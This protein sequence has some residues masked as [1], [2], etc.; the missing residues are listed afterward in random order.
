MRSKEQLHSKTRSAQ[1][2]S[3]EKK[4]VTLPLAE[5]YI[6]HVLCVDLDGTLV[7]SREANFLAYSRAFQH[8]G[9]EL[10]RELFDRGFGLRAEEFFFTTASGASEDE[11]RMI[12]SEKSRIYRECF[13]LVRVNESLVAFLRGQ[14][15]LRI[16]LVT[17]AS[18][19][20][21][22]QVLD[23]FGLSNLF[24]F[25][26]FGEDVRSAKPAPD[27]FLKA[28]ELAGCAP[29][30]CLAFEDSPAGIESASGAG[31]QIMRIQGWC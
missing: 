22:K 6:E 30:A 26:V 19:D 11:K 1:L 13:D 23:A 15:H 7:D 8:V 21:A 28:A 4:Y 24:A 31:C 20:N 14:S 12:R 17:S 18:R 2:S 29:E 27:A 25:E 10:E 16:G 5:V 3:S 9:R